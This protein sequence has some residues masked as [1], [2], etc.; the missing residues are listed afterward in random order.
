MI[1]HSANTVRIDELSTTFPLRTLNGRLGT[2]VPSDP[3]GQST[4]L[5]SQ[6]W[7]QG[8]LLNPV[9]G[10]RFD[11][12]KTRMTIGALDPSDYEGTINWVQME[13][14]DPAWNYDNVIKIDGF[15]G[16]NGS[17]IPWGSDR[18]A[19]NSRAQPFVV[20]Q[21]FVLIYRI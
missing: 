13:T 6:L 20:P 2:Y 4:N 1:T 14:P 10:F 9:M 19:I 18:A 8:R 11:P 5:F 17:I 16:Y 12:N 15:K 7:E 21:R 3:V